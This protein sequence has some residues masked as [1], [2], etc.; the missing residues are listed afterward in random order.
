[1]YLQLGNVD[2]QGQE[3]REATGPICKRFCSDRSLRFAQEK[4][5]SK[6]GKSNLAA[7]FT[8]IHT[9]SCMNRALTLDQALLLRSI[10]FTSMSFQQAGRGPHM[11][12]VRHEQQTA[13]ATHSKGKK[14]RS[15]E[16]SLSIKEHHPIAIG[17]IYTWCASW[18]SFQPLYS[19]YFSS[20]YPFS[21]ALAWRA[22]NE[23]QDF[24]PIISTFLEATALPTCHVPKLPKLPAHQMYS[25][26]KS[27][28]ACQ[29]PTD[30]P[31]NKAHDPQK[32]ESIC[33]YVLR[34]VCVCVTCLNRIGAS[35]N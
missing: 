27:C 9:S 16:R 4:L 34:Y 31:A 6:R 23:P 35:Y 25:A 21:Q 28:I 15:E 18:K 17:H 14:Q 26:T 3:A 29:Q 5:C 8:A 1:M 30:K 32:H 12:K 2:Y 22:N 7:E 13:K 24:S 19:P 33:I 11:Q 10:A 20:C